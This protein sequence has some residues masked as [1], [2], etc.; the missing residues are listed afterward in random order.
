MIMVP[1]VQCKKRLTLIHLSSSLELTGSLQ[2][3]TVTP[4]SPLLLFIFLFETHVL[5]DV[6]GGLHVGGGLGGDPPVR[7][8]EE[9][10]C[11]AGLLH[12]RV[13]LNSDEKAHNLTQKV[14]F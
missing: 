4:R 8:Q 3:L 12:V 9:D 14:N 2:T 13:D 10:A 7:P 1:T 5:V 6:A 11:R